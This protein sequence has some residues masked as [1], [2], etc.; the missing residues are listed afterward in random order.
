MK[1]PHCDGTLP[2]IIC[3][4][5]GGET[6]GGS[7]Y[8]CQCGKPIKIE[9]VEIDFSERIPCNDG[10]CIGIINEKKVCNICGKPYT[11]EPI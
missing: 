4:E 3:P 9:K 6:P 5:C 10:N 2:Y 7:L 11:G 1:C 8:C